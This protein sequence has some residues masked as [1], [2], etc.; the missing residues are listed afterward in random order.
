[1]IVQQGFA[2]D[3]NQSP[4]ESFGASMDYVG[5]VV[6]IDDYYCMNNI[7]FFK[8]IDPIVK[9]DKGG[10]SDIILIAGS[11]LADERQPLECAIGDTVLIQAFYRNSPY[12]YR[13]GYI[14]II[15]DQVL[16]SLPY[17]TYGY[18]EYKNG[19]CYLPYLNE[20][21]GRYSE[22]KKRITEKIKKSE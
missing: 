21:L 22:I 3:T 19:I 13:L 18:F 7:K 20:E 12:K 6:C 2:Q 16:Y 4:V 10:I 15:E 17:G 9:S 11:T 14:T 1:M 5:L 8:I